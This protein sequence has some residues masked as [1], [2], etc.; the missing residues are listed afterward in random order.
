MLTHTG[1]GAKIMNRDKCPFRDTS[2]DCIS[3]KAETRIDT[4]EIMS[5]NN[6]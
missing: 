4:E 1:T 6:Y 2:Q 5:V 3:T